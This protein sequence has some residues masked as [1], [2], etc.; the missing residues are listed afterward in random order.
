MNIIPIKIPVVMP[1]VKNDEKLLQ[2]EDLI[3][4]KRRMLLEKQKKIRF[5]A[6]QN[7][8]LD[9]VKNDYVKYYTYIAQQK[10]DQIKALQLLDNYI[11][12]LTRSGQLSKHNMED[13]KVEQ[14]KILKE[15]KS[16]KEG[17]ESIMENTQHIDAQI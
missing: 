4:S 12:D 2:I 16:I 14:N 13:A 17:L 1:L 10:Q 15:V 11:H 6:K 5:I 3:E 9:A 8:F 7:R